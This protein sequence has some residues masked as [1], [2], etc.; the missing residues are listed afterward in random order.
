MKTTQI[1][2]RTILILAL[3]FTSSALWA[4]DAEEDEGAAQDATSKT[5]DGA[6]AESDKKFDPPHDDKINSTPEV[7]S[8][9]A[10][11]SKAGGTSLAD[12]ATDPSA[13]LTQL[14]FF[15]WNTSSTDNRNSTMTGLFQPVL[16]LS[17]TNVF[18]PALPVIQTGGSDG[19]FGIG[20]LFLLDL[21]FVQCNKCTWGWGAVGTIPTATDPTLGSK[22][23]SAGP[24]GVYLYK[25]IPKSIL[26]ILAYNQWSFAGKSSRDDVNAMTLQ[27]V[28][29]KHLSW[30][31]IGWTDQ[32]TTIDWE[33]D[34]RLSF[35]VGLR[36]GKVFSGKT[37]LNFAIQ[38]YY[39]FRNKGLDNVWGLKLSATFIK[40]EWLRQ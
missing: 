3:I 23:W 2:G 34:N 40:P 19:K 18:R 1:T 11:A 13:I 8:H 6:A 5:E 38:P 35:P 20:D 33:H 16:P 7:D 9:E 10:G 14:G 29:V 36:F 4:M 15:A 26:G 21:N 31:Y 22:K 12:A 37:P 25:G 17:K 39:T 30:G 27:F 28:Y 24:G 32:T